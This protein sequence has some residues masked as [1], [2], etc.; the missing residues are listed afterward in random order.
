M[1]LLS[2]G[3]I[4]SFSEPRWYNPKNMADKI[5]ESGAHLALLQIPVYKKKGADEVLNARTVRA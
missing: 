4:G 5:R 3:T 1:N 2:G